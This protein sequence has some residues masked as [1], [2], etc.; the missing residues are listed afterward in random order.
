[1]PLQQRIQVNFRYYVSGD[2]V[3]HFM[4]F[5][6]FAMLPT[7]AAELLRVSLQAPENEAAA[8]HHKIWQRGSCM[9]WNEFTKVYIRFS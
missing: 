8:S 9:A 4:H 1:M 6:S 7:F 5:M 2:F 3:S